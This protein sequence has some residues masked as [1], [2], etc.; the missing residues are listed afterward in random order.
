MYNKK[1]IIPFDTNEKHIFVGTC[2][3]KAE[4]VLQEYCARNVLPIVRDILAW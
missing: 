1:N 2:L 3:K 4:S